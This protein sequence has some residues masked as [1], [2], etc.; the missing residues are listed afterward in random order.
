MFRLLL[1]VYGNDCDCPI[2][3]KQWMKALKCPKTFPQ[4]EEDFK[5]FKTIDLSTLRSKMLERFAN[6]HSICHYVVKNNK[7]AFCLIRLYKYLKT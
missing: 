4:L 7:V 6:H 5:P 3:A 1:D 2:N